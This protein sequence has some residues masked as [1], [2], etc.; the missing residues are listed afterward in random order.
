M[1]NIQMNSVNLNTNV[2]NA[3]KIQDAKPQEEA[4]PQLK[5]HC[6]SKAGQALKNV[7]LGVMLAASVIAGAKAATVP[8]KAADNKEI[9]PQTSYSQEVNAISD[10]ENAKSDGTVTIACHGYLNKCEGS[11][12]SGFR[13]YE[14]VEVNDDGTINFYTKDRQKDYLSSNEDRVYYTKET[15]NQFDLKGDIHKSNDYYEMNMDVQAGTKFE[16]IGN[17][18][19]DYVVMDGNCVLSVYDKNDN[20]VG[21]VQFKDYGQIEEDRKEAGPVVMG[22]LG[23]ILVGGGAAVVKDIIKNKKGG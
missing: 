2:S 17:K 9:L 3:K 21:S 15:K 6:S 1:N 18:Y 7:A 12:T 4:K 11:M 23:T 16:E 19:G 5:E 14:Y 22:A 13:N 10:A 20:K 8:A